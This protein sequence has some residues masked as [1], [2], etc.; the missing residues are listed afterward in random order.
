VPAVLVA[1]GNSSYSTYLI[2]VF[3]LPVVGKGWKALGFTTHVGP[4]AAYITGI[5]MTL[6]MGHILY[7]LIEHP[8]TRFLRRGAQS[9]KGPKGRYTLQPERNE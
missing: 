7:L 5:T 9:E 6:G 1:L 8:I 4:W 2:Q 3:T